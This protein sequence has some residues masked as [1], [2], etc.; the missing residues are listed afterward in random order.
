MEF[1][2]E[3][4]LQSTAKF[5]W[6]VKIKSIQE[7][8][9]GSRCVGSGLWYKLMKVVVLSSFHQ[10]EDV[11]LKSSKVMVNKELVEPV[12]LRRSSKSDRKFSNSMYCLGLG[13]F[14]QHQYIPYSF[15]RRL[16]K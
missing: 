16:H 12:V 9:W 3:C 6:S 11:A 8:E 10:D 7:L 15:A 4:V 5:G 2:K 1:K 14:R 13:T